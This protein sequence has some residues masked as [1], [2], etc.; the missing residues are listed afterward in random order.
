M[1][2]PVVLAILLSLCAETVLAC[3]CCA[4][5]A[6]RLS[7]QME[8]Q[9]YDDGEFARLRS[10][11]P[12]WVHTT[13]CGFDCVKGL[14]VGRHTYDLN[15]T[16]R[17]GVLYLEN[18]IGVISLPLTGEFDHF[19]V[20]TDP[21]ADGVDARLYREFRFAGEI[22]GS[23]MFSQTD[24]AKARLVLVGEGNSC[25]SAGDLRHWSLDLTGEKVDFRLFGQLFTGEE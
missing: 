22:E 23:G 16:I 11:G 25:W 8:R 3:A 18:A 5:R 1:L 7:E 13:A 12:A 24:G 21:F 17:E 14:E 19:A 4:D 2:R 10:I 15:L 20:D 6:D 9:A